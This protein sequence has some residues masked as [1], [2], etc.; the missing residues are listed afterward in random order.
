MS[1]KRRVLNYPVFLRCVQFAEPGLWRDT[2][3][4]LAYGVC[5]PGVFLTEPKTNPEAAQG[6]PG[7]TLFSKN[8]NFV[9]DFTIN[10]PPKQLYDDIVQLFTA[11]NVCNVSETGAF[12]NSLKQAPAPVKGWA[13]IKKK[14]IRDVL[15]QNYLIQKAAAYELTDA[16]LKSVHSFVST[17][18]TLNL[19]DKEDIVLAPEPPV[20]IQTIKKINFAH[21]RVTLDI[22]IFD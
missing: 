7:V 6:G 8:K 14:S 15:V 5:P 11:K 10:A 3:E 2:F 17:A 4:D 12:F 18:L 22:R 13:E 1:S 16:Q 21:H 19:L 9:Y 20:R